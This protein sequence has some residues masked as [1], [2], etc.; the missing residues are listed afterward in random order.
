MSQRIDYYCDCCGIKTTGGIMCVRI[1]SPTTGKQ[2]IKLDLCQTCNE[3]FDS[4][5]DSFRKE[6]RQ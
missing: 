5:I 6:Q 3:K 1:I 2:D 4:L